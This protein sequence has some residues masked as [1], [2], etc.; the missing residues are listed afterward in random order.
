MLLFP[1]SSIYWCCCVLVSGFQEITA[2]S[3]SKT[4]LGDDGH[5]EGAT[6]SP[7]TGS[8]AS[9]LWESSG[10]LKLGLPS[11]LMPQDCRRVGRCG[12]SRCM[13]GFS[14]NG[15][16]VVRT[17]A[18][19]PSTVSDGGKASLGGTRFCQQA[20]QEWFAVAK[21]EQGLKLTLG[22]YKL[23]PRRSWIS[24]TPST[25]RGAHSWNTLS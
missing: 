12:R 24:S 2:K 25:P 18:S 16:P 20:P 6:A 1:C 11:A 14:W 9:L 7:S 8:W 23:C 5:W 22:C 17:S 21:T 4:A 15:F 19:F 10:N 3:S 13:E